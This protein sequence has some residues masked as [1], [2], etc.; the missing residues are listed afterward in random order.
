MN[1]AYPYY[2]YSTKVQQMGD[3]ERRQEQK[4]IDF[5]TAKN[6]DYDDSFEFHDFGV[7]AYRGDN[8]ESGKLKTFIELVENGT[9]A[10]GSYLVVENF[11]RFSRQEPRKALKPFLNLIDMG[12]R[13]A[14]VDDNAI[15]SDTNDSSGL[16]MSI[17]YMER[18]HKES[19]DKGARIFEIGRASCRER[20]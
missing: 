12:I 9:I 17:M 16:M 20:V 14:V 18:A 19:K 5:C 6:L 11:D 15:H 4:A 3:S 13:I 7:S 2:R 8:L 10:K 1:K